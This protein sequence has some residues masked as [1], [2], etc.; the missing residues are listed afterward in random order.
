MIGDHPAKHI[1]PDDVLT[2]AEAMTATGYS[3]RVFETWC[4]KGDLLH[5]VVGGKA[6]VRWG[7]VLQC[8]AVKK[9][10][11]PIK[12]KKTRLTTWEKKRIARKKLPAHPGLLNTVN[13][14]KRK[15]K[16]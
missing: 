7:D 1:D 15:K 8:I 9:P 16:K 3:Y 12:D 5:E 14:E 6:Y 2:I 13:R 10:V 4:Q 11:T